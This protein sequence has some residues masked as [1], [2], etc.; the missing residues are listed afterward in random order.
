MTDHPSAEEQRSTRIASTFSVISTTAVVHRD[1]RNAEMRK[2]IAG[3]A[4][5]AVVAGGAAAVVYAP[6]DE[7][8]P[9]V[10][11]IAAAAPAATVA[12]GSEAFVSL[13]N[14]AT[15]D[16]PAA[17]PTT[18]VDS[19]GLPTDLKDVG[20]PSNT[21]YKQVLDYGFAQENAATI[22]S[23]TSGAGAGKVQFDAMSLDIPLDAS[24]PRLLKSMSAGYHSKAVRLVLRKAG[25]NGAPAV[26]SVFTFKTAFITKL[27]VVNGDEAPTVHL[28]FAYGAFVPSYYA[29]KADG[30]LDKPVTDGWS[31]ILNKQDASP[32]GC[33][34]LTMWRASAC[35]AASGT[36]A[37]VGG[38]VR[39]VRTSTRCAA[40]S[41]TRS[42]P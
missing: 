17:V 1:R 18:P 37:E 10:N 5:L 11:S 28:E 13:A 19:N 16:S 30:T 38:G 22:G 4:A 34:R 20:S 26:Y 25:V 7:A 23:A 6:S 31:V 39:S 36:L 3:V 2:I 27:E 8:K 29:Q 9:S 15:G 35:R 24:Y 14:L 41:A 12:G 33:C 40:T 32:Q 42:S 21:A